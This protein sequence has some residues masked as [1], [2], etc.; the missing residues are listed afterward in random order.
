MNIK[1]PATVLIL[2]FAGSA[3]AQQDLPSF[4]E[5]DQNSDGQIDQA[6]LATVEGVD[7]ETADQNQD[8]SIDRQ[9]WQEL[10]EGGQPGQPGQPGEPGQ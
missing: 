10:T 7:M 2:G 3:F 5:V 6:E 1:I 4:E 8:G 9:E